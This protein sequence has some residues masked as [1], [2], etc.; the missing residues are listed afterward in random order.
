MGFDNPEGTVMIAFRVEDM[1]CNHCVG[2]IRA[3]IEAAD[4]QA[5]VDIDL[6][7]HLVRVDPHSA[8]AEQLH[9]AITA[10]GY[11]PEPA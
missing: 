7:H 3:A 11:T 1:S 10:A 6:A 8:S 2:S 4:A 9:Q 5:Q